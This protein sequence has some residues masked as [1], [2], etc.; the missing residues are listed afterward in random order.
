[1]PLYELRPTELGRKTNWDPWYDK[2]FGF[3]IRA[4]TELSARKIADKEAGD[5]NRGEFLGEVL[6][7]EKHPWLNAEYSTCKEVKEKG[8]TELIIKDFRSA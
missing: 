8:K 1:M 6:S 4:R 3:L 2:C 5:E 7:K